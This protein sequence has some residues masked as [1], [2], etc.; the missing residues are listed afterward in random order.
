MARLVK[1]L[2]L[3]FGSGHNLNVLRAGPSRL[4]SMISG[5]LLEDFLL[6]LLAPLVLND[7]LESSLPLSFLKINLKKKKIHHFSSP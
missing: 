4:G 2:L 1:P 7:A 6:L 3:D 5:S